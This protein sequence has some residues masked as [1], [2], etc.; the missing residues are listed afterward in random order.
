MNTETIRT[1]IITALNE[2]KKDADKTPD[3][4]PFTEALAMLFDQLPN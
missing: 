4:T 2:G 1:A 3:D